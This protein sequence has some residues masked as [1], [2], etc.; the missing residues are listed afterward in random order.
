MKERKKS[1]M[2]PRFSPEICSHQQRRWGRPEGQPV[3]HVYWTLRGEAGQ[4]LGYTGRK[5]RRQV[6]PLVAY[7]VLKAIKLNK[8][9][10]AENEQM[11]K[12]T[13]PWGIPTQSGADNRNTV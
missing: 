4:A 12:E 6:W 11:I 9:V 5:L 10:R 8:S 1:K 3:G 2:T 7:K 13:E